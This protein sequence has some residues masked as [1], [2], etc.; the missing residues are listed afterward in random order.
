MKLRVKEI[1]KEKGLLMEQIALEL[2]ITPN[3]LTRNINGNPTIETLEK[4]AT[5]LGVG[6]TELFEENSG[7]TALIDNSGNLYRANSIDEL[8]RLILA[9][10]RQNP[11]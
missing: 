10:D 9:F 4:I 6:I 2:G 8:K 11:V 7:F 3:T 1:C 5:A